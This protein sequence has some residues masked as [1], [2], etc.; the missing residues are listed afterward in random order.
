M[1]QFASLSFDASVQ[2]MFMPLLAGGRV[3][4]APPDAP[5]LAAPAGRADPG[6]RR[7]VRLLT[8]AVVGLLRDEQFPGLRVLMCGG[9]ELPAE[10]GR[11]WLR[12][13]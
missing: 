4:L 6:P 12:P 13:A 2:D 10:P 7:H 1:L 11:P 8:P 3:V 9:E 5:A